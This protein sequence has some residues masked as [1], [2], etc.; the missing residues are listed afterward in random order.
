MCIRDRVEDLLTSKIDPDDLSIDHELL[1]AGKLEGAAKP[2]DYKTKSKKFKNRNFSR[3]YAQG[4]RVFY[5]EGSCFTCHRDHGEGIVRIYPPLVGSEWVTGDVDRLTKLT[6]HGIW[7]KIRVRGEIFQPAKGVPPM[8]AIGNFFTDAEVAAVL[9]YVRN[10]WGNDASQVMP[11]D[12]KRIREETKSRVKFYDPEELL[13]MHPFPEGSRPPMIED[14]MNTELEQALLAEP[15]AD[16]VSAA[17]KDGNAK[18]G[19]KVFYGK[20]TACA[21]CHDV[22]NGYQM[23]PKLTAA[24]EQTTP[25]FLVESI[26]KPS[27]SILKGYQTVNVVN[28]EGELLTGFLVAQTDEAI[29]ISIA[30]DGGKPRTIPMDEVEDVTPMELS[31]MPNGLASLCEDRQAFLDLVKFVT[32]INQ[33][34]PKRLRQIKRQAKIK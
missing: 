23:G 15:L 34:G 11:E 1:L 6:L 24:R 12:V 3:A 27:A 20:R 33:G 9:T 32:E 13:E 14:K 19:A 30:A 7:G 26:L 29:T 5:E 10:S 31:S 16:L 8:T 28:D 21:S 17:Q 2:K 22:R 4:E 18:N 25:E